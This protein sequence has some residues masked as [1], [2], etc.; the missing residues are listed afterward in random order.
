MS[1]E[2]HF[3]DENSQPWEGL[4]GLR[5][6]DEVRIDAD[7]VYTREQTNAW[8]GSVGLETLSL[9]ETLSEWSQRTADAPEGDDNGTD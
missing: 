3:Y 4:H 7:K 5:G 2:N 1:I 8:L 6:S 9:G